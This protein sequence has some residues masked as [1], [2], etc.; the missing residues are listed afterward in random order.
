MIPEGVKLEAKRRAHYQCV[1]CRQ[2]KFLHVHHILPQEAGGPA[3]L[4]NAAPLCVECHDLYG[5]DPTKRKWCARRVTF[6]GRTARAR[7]RTATTA[8]L[9]KFDAL[10]TTWQRAG[11]RWRSS[12]S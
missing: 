2:T 12:R 3:T 4:D 9:Q 7:S 1:I 5:G 6:G 8:L 10:Q 11:A